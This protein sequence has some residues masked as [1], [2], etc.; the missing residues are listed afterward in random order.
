MTDMED[1]REAIRA[2]RDAFSEQADYIENNDVLDRDMY[3]RWLELRRRH[4][5]AQAN[6]DMLVDLCRKNC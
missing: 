1:L 2:W 4:D 6:V 3:V 5:A